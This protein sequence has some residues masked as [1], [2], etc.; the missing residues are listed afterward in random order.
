MLTMGSIISLFSV[1]G[2]S[3]FFLGRICNSV[4]IWVDFTLI[5]ST[6]SFH[7][8]VSPAELGL[9]AALYGLP[10]L[11]LGPFVGALA[12]R[13]SPAS[14]MLASAFARFVASMG[15]AFASNETIFIVWIFIKGVSNLGAIPAEQVLIR[16]LL[17]NEQIVST[18]ALTSVLDQCTKILA[19][20]LGAGL[21]FALHSRGG[22]ALTGGLALLSM[23][24]AIGVAGAVG[25][26]SV[27]GNSQRRYP[28]FV[29]VRRVISE[30]PTF[31]FTLGLALTS[32]MVL[33]LYDSI[34]VVLLRDHGL[35]DSSFGTIV[36]CTAL[37]AIGCAVVLKNL[38]ARGSESKSLVIFV[39]GFSGSVV[40]AGLLALMLPTLG[41]GIL[42]VLWIINGFCYGGGMMAYGIALQKEVPADA[43][44]VVSTSARS[45]QLAALVIGPVVGSGIAQCI[46]V[47]A[48]FVGAG[49]IG[50]AIAAWAAVRRTH[51]RRCAN[52]P[53]AGSEN[54][55]A[56]AIESNHRAVGNAG[57]AGEANRSR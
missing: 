2:Y 26:G 18:V 31:A 46:G 50:L 36:S 1:R 10:G 14:I 20:L 13:K 9:S 41:L 29:L 33:G 6:L 49:A 51:E 44:G 42:C 56:E 24:C 5:F 34:V 8:H 23:G 57:E 53:V 35:P 12:D 15:L 37:G 11:L 19:P 4:A 38:L 7:Y 16:R 40:A 3:S 22:F 54:E 47:E 45:L 52:L 17:S 39:A 27:S 25:W 30:N 43:L 48:T 28:D 21:S 32:S 55:Y